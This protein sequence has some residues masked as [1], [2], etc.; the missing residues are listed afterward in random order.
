MPCES[1]RI[2]II[3]KFLVLATA[4]NANSGRQGRDQRIAHHWLIFS[5]YILN[6]PCLALES[7]LSMWNF[8]QKIILLRGE[9]YDGRF[10]S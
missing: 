2:D 1:F 5:C 7:E 10:L 3:L 6:E 8:Q 4:Q 9:I